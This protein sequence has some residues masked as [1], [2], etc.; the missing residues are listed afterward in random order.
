M[1]IPELDLRRVEKTL[2]EYCDKK[3]PRHVRDKLQLKF[4]KRGNQITL[5]EQRPM[6]EFM[7]KSALNPGEPLVSDVAKFVYLPKERVW[8]LKWADR[9]NR[10]HEYEGF[11]L[12]KRFE[13]LLAEVDADPTAI[14][15]G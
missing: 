14:F 15:W 3:V 13:D 6:P 10:W 1:P 12:E 9:N 2:E 8:C 5:F 4:R 7:M 11:E